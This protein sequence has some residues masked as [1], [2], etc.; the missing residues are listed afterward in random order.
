MAGY[1]TDF[2]THCPKCGNFFV[3]AP[4]F[5]GKCPYCGYHFETEED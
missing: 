2:V 4:E 1:E 3:D 5:N